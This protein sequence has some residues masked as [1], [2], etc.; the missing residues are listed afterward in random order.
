M[1]IGLK[2]PCCSNRFNQLSVI[3]PMLRKIIG[4]K[5]L[6][7]T[8]ETSIRKANIKEIEFKL[9]WFKKSSKGKAC[10][11]CDKIPHYVDGNKKFWCSKCLGVVK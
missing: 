9:G 8:C 4:Y 1:S 3:D 2:C 11:R 7:S 6:C 10:L 5:K